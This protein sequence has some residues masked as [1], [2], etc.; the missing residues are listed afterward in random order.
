MEK[1]SFMENL[2]YYFTSDKLM[3]VCVCPNYA[4]HKSLAELVI[5]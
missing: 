3:F 1:L 2:V 5:D 4:V